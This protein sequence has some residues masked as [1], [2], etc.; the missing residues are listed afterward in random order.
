[1]AYIY[2]NQVT[3]FLDDRQSTSRYRLSLI[4]STPSTILR[5]E[6]LEIVDGFF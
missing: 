5:T 2:M 4:T 1:M 3:I 6:T